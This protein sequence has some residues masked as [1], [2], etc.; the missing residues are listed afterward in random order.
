M[1]KRERVH[2]GRSAAIVPAGM[3][4]SFLQLSLLLGV[5][6][7]SA[8]AE[9]LLLSLQQRDLRLPDGSVVQNYPAYV[10]ERRAYIDTLPFDGIAIHSSTG[11]ATGL[12]VMSGAA[13][14]YATITNEWAPL[15]G[16]SFT[17]V[18]HNFAVVNVGRPADF[19]GDWSTTIR[20][21]RALARVLKE[22][23][24]EGVFFD[25]EEYDV[26]L[27]KYPLDC[28]YAGT[29]SL[30]QYYG[31]VRLRGR[32][33]M[34][35]MIAEFPDIVFIVAHS[36]SNSYRFTPQVVDWWAQNQNGYDS[37]AGAFT[38]GVLEGAG[39]QAIVVDGG[40]AAYQYRHEA[41]YQTS[42][43]YRKFTLASA[44]VNCPFIPRAL[45]SSWPDQLSVAYGIYNLVAPPRLDAIEPGKYQ[46]QL[47][48]ALT[49]CD[50]YT[51]AYWEGGNWYIPPDGT[52][53][54]G[55]PWFDAVAAARDGLAS[56]DQPAELRGSE[57]SGPRRLRAA[58]RRNRAR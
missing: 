22:T 56:F 2:C 34:Q 38:V 26:S 21:F 53:G 49:N 45:R 9:S 30:E 15:R 23:G 44:S 8:R 41:E 27:W 4:R 36:P 28:D 18:T 51:W 19:F 3:L 33:I 43:Q 39:T 47:E 10:Y 6:S 20:N 31:Q 35:A 5:L 14:S 24:I 29:T 11:G 42:Y 54:V 13:I 46:S 52:N 32:Q 7:C 16:V 17:R 57:R 55:Q 25:N 37:L 40:E 58:R 12:G 48:F 1:T 50:S